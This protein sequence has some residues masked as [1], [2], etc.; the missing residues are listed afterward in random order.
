M[1][2]KWRVATGVPMWGVIGK[3]QYMTDELPV[4]ADKND[5]WVKR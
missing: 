3:T 5:K 4:L 2:K 1:A